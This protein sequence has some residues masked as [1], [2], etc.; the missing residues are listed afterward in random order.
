MVADSR[1]N[2]DIQ[3]ITLGDD[4]AIATMKAL[5]PDFRNKL[6]GEQRKII[7]REFVKPV[8]KGKIVPK[9]TKPKGV[10]KRSPGR[11]SWWPQQY[12]KHP[13]GWKTAK[14]DMVRFNRIYRKGARVKRNYNFVS[15]RSHLRDTVRTAKQGQR[16]PWNAVRVLWGNRDAGVPHAWW[17][18]KRGE[19]FRE[20]AITKYASKVIE[21]ID[22]VYKAIVS[23]N[24]K[25]HKKLVASLGF[26][27]GV[28]AQLQRHANRISRA[29]Y[30]KTSATTVLKREL[31]RNED[32]GIAAY[33]TPYY[34]AERGRKAELVKRATGSYRNVD[35]DDWRA[36]MRAA[37]RAAEAE[38]RAIGF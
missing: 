37:E 14:T 5:M 6:A 28:P 34:G 20:A 27:V 18:I 13:P 16:R 22:K 38:L 2:F 11:G 35:V 17:V 21:E 15:K 32:K 4:Y 29:A 33:E 10:G 31:A 24:A 8:K 7:E 30:K 25:E 12:S 3:A 9:S 23:G 36:H 26:R 1:N 19:D